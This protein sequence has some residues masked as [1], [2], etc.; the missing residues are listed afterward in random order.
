MFAASVSKIVEEQQLDEK[1]VIDIFMLLFP[2]P[3][4]TLKAKQL[5]AIADQAFTTLGKMLDKERRNPFDDDKV[6]YILRIS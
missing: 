3:K 1:L 2:E 5:K 4:F 6:Y